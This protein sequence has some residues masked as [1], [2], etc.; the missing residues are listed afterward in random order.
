MFS[1]SFILSD[2][3][4]HVCRHHQY[5]SWRLQRYLRHLSD[6]PVTAQSSRQRQDLAIIDYRTGTAGSDTVLNGA[7]VTPRLV[8]RLDIFWD[9]LYNDWMINIDELCRFLSLLDLQLSDCADF[10]NSIESSFSFGS[11]VVS[12]SRTA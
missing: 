1:N 6:R 9:W 10:L 11:S 12:I 2:L 5:P 4:H 3:L 8:W 7:W